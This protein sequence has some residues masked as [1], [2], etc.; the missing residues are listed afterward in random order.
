[1]ARH[2]VNPIIF[3]TTELRRNLTAI[4]RKIRRQRE[5]AIIQSGGEAVAVLLP[6]SEY[7]RYLRYQ[8]LSAFDKFARKIGRD[9]EKSGLTEEQLMAELEE[10]KREVFREKYGD[11]K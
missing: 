7:E 11:L 10:T 6:I 2:N 8:R 9:V 1:M 5:P 4:V 3:T